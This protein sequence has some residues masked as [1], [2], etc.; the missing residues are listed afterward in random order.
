[1]KKIR[2][3]VLINSLF[4]I[5][6]LMSPKLLIG[7]SCDDQCSFIQNK[8]NC[9]DKDNICNS[10]CSLSYDHS[11]CSNSCSEDC[12]IR[13]CNSPLVNCAPVRT[14][15]YYRSVG[16]NIAREL[17]GWQWE[18]YRPECENYG[19][20]YLA[21]EYQ[22]TFDSQRLIRP[23]FGASGLNFAGS[24]VEDRL[25][26]ALIADNFGLSRNCVGTVSFEPLI[27]NHIFDFGFYF[28]LNNWCEG[29]FIKLHAPVVHTRWDLDFRC[30]CRNLTNCASTPF[31]LCYVSSAQ[32]TR[33]PDQDATD[34]ENLYVANSAS[35]FEQALSG[36]FLF[37]DMQTPW[38]GAR[39]PLCR[40]TRTRVG[41]I[42]FNL[43]YNWLLTDCYH[44]GGFIKIVAPTGNRVSSRYIF[45]PQAGNGH[46]WEIGAGL[47]AHDVLWTGEDAN[48]SV[49][50]EG[51]ITH[52]L[53]DR[54]CRVFDLCNG[55]MSRY[56]LLKE[57]LSNGSE[58]VYSGNLV[59]ANNFTTRDVDVKINIKGDAAVKF[60]YRW[61]GLG[62]DLGYEIYGNEH[63]TIERNCNGTSYDC[64]RGDIRLGI[65]G[66]ETVCCNNF[67]IIQANP[68]SDP[69]E[70]IKFVA[71]NG[72]QLS[73]ITTVGDQTV[74]NVK[75]PDNCPQIST[76]TTTLNRNNNSQPKANM[77]T[78]ILGEARVVSPI[79]STACTVCLSP[80]GTAVTDPT[81]LTDLTAKNGYIVDNTGTTQF[82]GDGNIN[83]R[84][85]EGPSVL[86]HKIFAHVNYT[87]L[88]D[89]GWNPH[90]GIG[91]EVE[92][93][94][95]HHNPRHNGNRNFY[96][97]I[98][99]NQWGVW[100][101]G[102]V[103]F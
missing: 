74:E 61:C 30:A 56:L 35:T 50:F 72:T 90:I 15:I 62:V 32:V 18:L 100:I 81:A 1:M 39:F 54:Q 21:Y 12:Q 19:T 93:D 25:P 92:F 55:A 37:G 42:D 46:H 99:F 36:T 52:M 47:T 13:Y 75:A 98:G 95:Q 58:Y 6:A 94:G 67:P 8:R 4:S 51:Y 80:D 53:R 2:S 5:L 38:R 68:V 48:L 26:N 91:F 17:V 85:A 34:D 23:L 24:L 73:T 45:S 27:E 64:Y 44:F 28:G 78:P 40:R 33:G 88:D 70:I 102:G 69:D 79:S 16:D 11:C 63:E 22:R 83:Y 43:G 89:C 96:D 86:C 101:K 14:Q 60:A 97:R 31:S 49:W 82:I 57:Y 9:G 59:S 76:V 87:W 7:D 41:D 77:F 3:K 10:P 29:L 66:T 103:S 71:P 84:S 65:K 20:L